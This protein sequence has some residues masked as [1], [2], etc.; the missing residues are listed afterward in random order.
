MPAPRPEKKFFIA[1]GIEI[2]GH[3]NFGVAE[4]GSIERYDGQPVSNTHNA[5]VLAKARQLEAAYVEPLMPH[6]ELLD[7]L[8]SEGIVPASKRNQI[9]GRLSTKTGKA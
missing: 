6:E 7:A 5:Q 9:R 4:D 8:I 2:F 3:A 1:A